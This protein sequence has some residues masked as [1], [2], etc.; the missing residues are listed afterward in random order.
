MQLKNKNII[1]ITLLISLSIISGAIASII[2]TKQLSTT[3]TIISPS[4]PTYSLIIYGGDGVTEISTINWGNAY[5]NN[6]ITYTAYIKNN[7]DGILYI[8][9]NTTNL[10]STMTFTANY[11]SGRYKIWNTPIQINPNQQYEIQFILNTGNT[12]DGSY[13]FNINIYGS[14]T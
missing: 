4:Q 2:I 11:K 10:P 1:L 8:S 3:I 5:A 9:Q 14:T 7:G 6:Q 12:S 13:P